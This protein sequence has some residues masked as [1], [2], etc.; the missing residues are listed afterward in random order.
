MAQTTDLLDDSLRVGKY[1]FQFYNEAV[2]GR[3]P[4][5]EYGSASYH[6]DELVLF[7]VNLTQDEITML[8][9]KLSNDGE[10]I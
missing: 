3:A 6:I 7:D 4:A 9:G 5:P 2:S 1:F 10:I 8:E